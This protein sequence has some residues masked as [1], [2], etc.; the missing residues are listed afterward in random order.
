MTVPMWYPTSEVSSKLALKLLEA[1]T[2]SVG[3]DDDK[4]NNRIQNTGST[5]D[6]AVQEFSQLVEFDPIDDDVDGMDLSNE[7]DA[8][9][10]ISI[11]RMVTRANDTCP[12]KFNFKLL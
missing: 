2:L 5:Q 12:K 3:M 9:T 4:L 1:N 8:E 11:K 7:N 6:S 10:E